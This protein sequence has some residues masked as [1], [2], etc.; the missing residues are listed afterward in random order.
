M[1]SEPKTHTITT[2][3]TATPEIIN[4]QKSFDFSATLTGPADLSNATILAFN[5][6]TGEYEA[7]ENLTFTGGGSEWIAQANGTWSGTPYTSFR[8]EG[9]TDDENGVISVEVTRYEALCL[10]GDT[11]ITLADGSEKRLDEL[12]EIDV[13]MGGDMQPAKILRL[14]RGHWNSYHILYRFD[15]GITIDEVHEHRFYNVEQGFW[16]KL[17]N[18]SIGE[19]ARRIDG[20]TAALEAVERIE[21]RKEMF[22]LW[23]ERDSYWAN[24]LLSG[25][26]EAN[27]PLLCDATAEK[28]A[29]MAAS[30]PEREIAKLLRKEMET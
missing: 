5:D 15:D 14:A 9:E 20:G 23:V 25:D 10:A 13:V 29:E 19:H 6:D 24:G 26:A 12:T 3:F 22:G 8:A 11:L 28:A 27:L 1:P 4:D 21:E 30:L 16:Q 7:L 2:E 17:K 18:W